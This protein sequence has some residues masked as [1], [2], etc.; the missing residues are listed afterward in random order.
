MTRKK[1]RDTLAALYIAENDTPRLVSVLSSHQ[2]E[3]SPELVKAALALLRNQALG[4]LDDVPQQCERASVLQRMR[5]CFDVG[6]YDVGS[7]LFILSMLL[8]LRETQLALELTHSLFDAQCILTESVL[9]KMLAALLENGMTEDARQLLKKAEVVNRLTPSVSERFLM[10]I[11]S[12]NGESHAEIIGT[13]RAVAS[14]DKVLRFVAWR[15]ESE[16]TVQGS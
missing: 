13:V 11:E 7:A 1:I 5:E 2:G 4:S 3:L 6:A 12:A 16:K 15:F 14:Q 10:L 8:Q 9:A